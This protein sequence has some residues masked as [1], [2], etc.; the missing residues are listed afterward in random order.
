[1]YRNAC[2]ILMSALMLLAGG[3]AVAGDLKRGWETST[4][5]QV[6]LNKHLPVIQHTAV[7]AQAK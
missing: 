7:T 2:F 3:T 6:K 5:R 1:M 4:H